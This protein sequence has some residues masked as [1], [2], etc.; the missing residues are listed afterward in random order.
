MSKVKKIVISCIAVFL[1]IAVAGGGIAY[2]YL[3]YKPSKWLADGDDSIQKA[4]F[5]ESLN[6]L[7]IMKNTWQT[8]VN[9]TE[10]H[11]IILNHF[12]SSLPEGKTKKKAIVIGYDGCRTDLLTLLPTSKRS[13]INHLTDNGGEAIFS[14]CGGVNYPAKNTQDTSTAPGWCSM[15]TGVLAD[16]HHITGNDISKEVEPKSLLIK[17]VEDGTIDKSS[18]YVSWKGHFS[19]KNA[20]YLKELD[21][22]NKNNIN[23]AFLRGNDDKATRKNI[24]DDLSNENCSDFIFSTFEYTDHAGHNFGFA[25][26][27]VRYVSGFRDADATGLDIIEA[28]ENRKTYNEEDWLIIITT[29]HGGIEK[30]HGGP[31]FEERIT[32]IVSNKKIL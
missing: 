10:I 20:T 1:V 6:S 12:N 15:L 7:T 23:S 24:L 14:Y 30:E 25:L 21:Y 4:D 32:F 9:Q 29:D 17:L 28:I 8:A 31:S 19:R 16:S 26:D 2:H 5:E 27:N 13:A 3:G 11:N 18:F 22:I